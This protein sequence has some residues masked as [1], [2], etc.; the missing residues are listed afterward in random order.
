MRVPG[1]TQYLGS[2]L[3]HDEAA[4]SRI[5]HYYRLTAPLAT[6]DRWEHVVSAGEDDAG[7]LFRLSFRPLTDPGLTPGF[8]WDGEIEKVRAA[9]LADT[10]RCTG[11]EP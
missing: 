4:P 3:W 11:S 9:V 7:M 8:G 10:S 5:R 2:H 6:P 1:P